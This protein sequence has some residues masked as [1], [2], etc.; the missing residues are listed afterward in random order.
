MN[1]QIYI[2]SAYLISLTAILITHFWVWNENKQ[3]KKKLEKL[4]MSNEQ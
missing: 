3:L 1:N 4:A 2:Y